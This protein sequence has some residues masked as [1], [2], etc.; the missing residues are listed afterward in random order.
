MNP[1]PPVTR[2]FILSPG[3][4]KDGADRPQNNGKIHGKTSMF[5]VIK[6]VFQLDYGFRHAGNISIIELCPASQTWL[7]EQTRPIER[8]LSLVLFYQTGSLCT[9]TDKTH[10]AT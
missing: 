3:T 6:I 7:D 8:N 5:D 2:Y 9:R 4:T 10:L 1:A